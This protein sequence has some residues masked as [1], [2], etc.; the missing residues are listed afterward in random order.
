VKPTPL[1]PYSPGGAI[2]DP[3]GRGFFGRDEIFEFVQSAIQ[4]RQRTPIILY[5]Q[6]RIGKSS[7][8]RQIPHHL[9]PEIHCVYYDLQGKAG[10]ELD[11]VLFGLAREISREIKISMPEREEAGEETFASGFLARAERAL[12]GRLDRLVILFD[13]FDVLDEQIAEKNVAGR[14]FIGYLGQ[15]IGQRPQ[16]GYALVIGRKT[17]ELSPEFNSTLLK[18]SVQ[19]RIGRLDETHATELVRNM[20][21]TQEFL[22]FSE[23]ALSRI[24]SLTAG[25][26]YCAQL[27]CFTI[28]SRGLNSGDERVKVTPSLVEDAVAPA[29]DFGTHGLNWIFDGLTIPAYR[30]FLSALAEISNPLEGKSIPFSVIERTLLSHQVTLDTKEFARAPDDLE[31]WEIISRRGNEGF[32]FQVPLIGMW[33][34]QARPL[35]LLER[36]VRYTNPRAYAY[37]ELA[38]SAHEAGDPDRAITDYEG[39][40]E[41]NP[42]FFEAQR[43]L[44]IALRD[45]A[46]PTDLESAIEAYE[47]ALEID[48]EMPTSDL[49]QAL[50]D[51]L[52]APGTST[53]NLAAY[54]QRLGELDIDGRMKPR[55]DRIL[56]D[57]AFQ[58]MKAEHYHDAEITFSLL[59]ED[60]LAAL[61]RRQRLT[62]IV[63]NV[64]V[65]L[66]G[67]ISLILRYALSSRIVPGYKQLLLAFAGVSLSEL[68]VGTDIFSPETRL[69]TSRA[70][71]LLPKTFF[72]KKSPAG[73]LFRLVLGT[74]V[75]FAAGYLSYNWFHWESGDLVG[76]FVGFYA[77][78]VLRFI[79]SNRDKAGA[80]PI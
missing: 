36:E 24:Y 19:Q 48:S 52:N 30:L 44:A 9:P 29:L 37:Y 42:Y 25:H 28:W 39:A 77:A 20:A 32:Q 2:A 8:L 11:Q 18:N 61:A 63:I 3:S 79:L 74:V 22:D 5:G 46:G 40:L 45:R 75:G 70:R 26:P 4:A 23:E 33:I 47:R 10:M 62:V 60:E 53:E 68:L 12:G 51:A 58:M 64:M 6:R 69:G 14:Q 41:A 65:A 16:I 80:S 31:R 55:G 57:R 21:E 1:N 73:T 78:I 17:E 27:L 35:E 49:V 56:R 13:E 71:N 72:S 43:D 50:L 66:L 38:R 15:L 7:I 54:Y 76:A 59:H 67:G 34:R